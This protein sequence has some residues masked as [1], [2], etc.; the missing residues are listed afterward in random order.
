MASASFTTTITD[1]QVIFTNT[2]TGHRFL[3]DF[4]DG[5]ITNSFAPIYTYKKSGTY[6]VALTAIDS[7]GFSTVTNEV[8]ILEPSPRGA[9]WF[10]PFTLPMTMNGL[11]KSFDTL[12]LKYEGSWHTY[13]TV[14]IT[15]P[16]SS[17]LITN[18]GTDTSISLIIGISK[19]SKRVLEYDYNSLSWSLTDENGND[20]LYEL[21]PNSNFVNFSIQPYNMITEMQ[22]IS[23][24]LS[25]IGSD[26]SAIVEYRVAEFGH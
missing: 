17:A 2:S 8:I 1:F 13:P 10:M 19:S 12:D 24:R 7:A 23:I 22:F 11:G 14:T 16:Y 6:S 21:S 26:T 18:R 5:N 3:W 25:G 20:K 15:G 4:G 9:A